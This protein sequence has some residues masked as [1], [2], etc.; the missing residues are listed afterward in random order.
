MSDQELDS[1]EITLH[2]DGGV[3]ENSVNMISSASEPVD[4]SNSDDCVHSTP[5]KKVGLIFL[6]DTSKP[7]SSI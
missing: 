3:A 7:S 4:I 1:E 5:N 6:T 2:G